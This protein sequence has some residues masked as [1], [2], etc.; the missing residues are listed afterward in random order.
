MKKNQTQKIT[1]VINFKTGESINIDD[2]LFYTIEKQY[3]AIWKEAEIIE[4]YN[5]D[6]ILSFTVVKELLF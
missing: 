2:V 6:N 5:N 3:L 1:I 4:Y